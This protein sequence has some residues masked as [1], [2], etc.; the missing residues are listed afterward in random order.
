[1]SEVRKL[2]MLVVDDDRAVCSSIK[3]LFQRKNF[4]VVFAHL[5]VE[6]LELFENFKPDIVLLDMNFTVDTSGIQGL[7]LLEKI[8]S[9]ILGEIRKF[10]RLCTGELE[11]N[12]HE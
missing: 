6:A 10:I 11:K 8:K 4:E 7:K 12:K 3:L 5:P 2:K 9:I 1:M